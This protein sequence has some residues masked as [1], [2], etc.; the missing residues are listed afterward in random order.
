MA[1]SNVETADNP[2]ARQPSE[3]P[4][5]AKDAPGSGLVKKTAEKVESRKKRQKSRL[6]EIM[7]QTRKNNR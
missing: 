1:K 3:H 7:K 5:T 4:L 6:D 2:E